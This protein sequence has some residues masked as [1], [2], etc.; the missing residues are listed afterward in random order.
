MVLH[1]LHVRSVAA[2]RAHRGLHGVLVH[3]DGVGGSVITGHQQRRDMP[4]LQG[5]LL[6]ELAE[7]P[8][9][10]RV[11]HTV[12]HG[13]TCSTVVGL[14]QTAV[15]LEREGGRDH[16]LRSDLP[17]RAGDVPTQIQAVLQHPVRVIQDAQIAHSYL[18][19]RLTLL[20]GTATMH[21]TRSRERSSSSGSGGE[22][23]GGRHVLHSPT[24]EG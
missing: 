16:D 5:L 11:P 8:P 4:G 15:C 10:V 1:V 22:E 18:C 20:L 19:A 23:C 9:V 13:Q 14:V 7:H 24:V 3:G 17:D 12:H 6:S 2:Q 21:S